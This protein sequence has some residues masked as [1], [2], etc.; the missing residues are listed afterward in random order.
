MDSN[1]LDN[2]VLGKTQSINNSFEIKVKCY[3]ETSLVQRKERHVFKQ[4]V[5]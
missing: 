4:Y 5:Y 2:T 3:F 1:T